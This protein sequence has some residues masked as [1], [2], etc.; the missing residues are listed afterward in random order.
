M[1]NFFPRWTNFLPLKL[2]ICA[3]L[4]GAGLTAAFAY[5]AT[6]KAQRVGYQ[7][8][9]PT[10]YDHELHVNQLGL[11]CRYCHSFV[12]HSG[13]ANIPSASTCWNCHRHVAKDSPKLEPLRDAMG[14][15]QDHAPLEGEALKRIRPIKWVK[16]HRSPDYVFFNHSAHVNRG[17]SCQSCHGKVNE[18]KVV[19]QAEPHSMSWCLDCHRNP[20]PHLRPL[21]EVFN[22]D[23]DV[24][25]YLKA[26]PVKDKDGNPI[27]TQKAFGK[28]LRERWGIHP[29]EGCSTCHR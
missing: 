18:M 10:P 20:D 13:Q 28:H 27:T 1:A 6:P 9:Q 15:D 12:E 7:P 11:D 21:E 14:V 4:A 25:A 19:Y 5:Y 16:V 17:V 3:A 22:L 2:A 29:K 8:S 24:E 23:Y 26:N